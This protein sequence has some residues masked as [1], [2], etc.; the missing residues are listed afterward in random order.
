M[1]LNVT[2]MGKDHVSVVLIME[3]VILC[4]CIFYIR[5]RATRGTIVMIVL[6]KY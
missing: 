5:L 2:V 6:K 1:Q 3:N 4:E